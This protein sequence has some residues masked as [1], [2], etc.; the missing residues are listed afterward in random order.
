VG[1]RLAQN[2]VWGENRLCFNIS[3]NGYSGRTMSEEEEEERRFDKKVEAS[4]ARR[5]RR[6]RRAVLG[7]VVPF[8]AIG[9][10]VVTLLIYLKP[11]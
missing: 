9:T 7:L 6:I 5:R 10:F 1:F 8:C 2:V 11:A 3:A 4:L